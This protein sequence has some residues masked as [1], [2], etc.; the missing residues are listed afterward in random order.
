MRS[1]LKFRTALVVLT[2]ITLTGY[3]FSGH[4][5]SLHSPSVS[6]QTPRHQN[7]TIGDVSADKASSNS[8]S[9][10]SQ[11]WLAGAQ[12]EIAAREY[13][14]SDRDG[15]LQAPNR[16]QGFRAH[17]SQNGVELHERDGNEK[18][19][20]RMQFSGV[21]KPNGHVRSAQ[22]ITHNENRFELDH[23][24]GVVEWFVN[25][26][27]GLEHGY[28]VKKTSGDP[29]L[30]MQISVNGAL[31]D[32]TIDGLRFET[33]DG[34]RFD[35]NQLHAFDATGHELPASLKK[36]ARDSFAI[37][38]DTVNA[39]F[40]ITI[41]PILTT[42]SDLTLR[43]NQIYAMFGFSTANAGDVNGDGFDDLV[44]GAFGYDNGS[45]SEGVAFVFNGSES[46]LSTTPS[47]ILESNQ[48]GAYLGYSVS[49]A[50]D[51]N[52]DGFADIIVGVPQHSNGQD[53]E[54]GAY[55][56]LGSRDGIVTTPHV[57]VESDQARA[58]FG[59]SVAGAGDINGDGY[60][61]VIVGSPDFDNEDNVDAGA[62]FIYFGSPNGLDLNSS[63]QF[64]NNLLMTYY[65]GQ[66]AGA[67]D[68]NADGFD[69]VVVSSPTFTH[70]ENR[71][72]RV[73]VYFG[74]DNGID[75]SAAT[76]LESNQ[77]DAYFGMSVAGAGDVNGDGYADIIVGSTGSGFE[78]THEGAAFIFLGGEQ[79]LN[80]TAAWQVGSG[81]TNSQFGF[82]V[83][84]LGDV[85][86]DGFADVA[87][88]SFYF[89]NTEVDDGAVYIYAGNANGASTVALATLKGNKASSEFGR[90]VSGGDFNG[91][92]YADLVVGNP[93]DNQ[94][95]I[96]EGS[97][98][99]YG[100]GPNGLNTEQASIFDANQ[101]DAALGSSI[102]NAGDINGDGFNDIILG[103]PGF[104]TGF[105]NSGA[106]FIY[107]GSDT[108]LATN[109]ITQLNGTQSEAAFGRSVAGAGDVNGDG[110]A[111]I[112]VGSDGFDHG[113]QNEGAAFI[114]LGSASGINSTVFASLESNQ[115]DAQF[116]FSVASAGD[117]NGDGFSDIIVGS[118][119]YDHGQ[120]DEGAAFI[121][122]GHSSVFNTTAA[123]FLESNQ[124]NSQFAF[125]VA[126]AGDVNGDSLSDIAIG[127]P[128][129]DNGQNDEGAVFVYLG[130]T[131]VFA[132][133]IFATLDSNQAEARLGTSVAGAGDINGDGLDDFAS[134]APL[135]D[136]TQADA[137]RVFVYY[138]NTI[139]IASATATQLKVEQ[140]SAQFGASVAGA[141]DINSDGFAD[142]IVGSPLYDKQQSDEGVVFV[143]AGKA[144]GLIGAAIAQIEINQD[145]A[146]FGTS[147]AA[148]GDI[149][150]DGFAELVIG[151]PDYDRGES[152]EGAGFVYSSADGYTWKLNQFRGDNVDLPVYDGLMSHNAQQFRI[153]LLAHA[154]SG[155]AKVK[156]QVETCPVMTSFASAACS[157][158]VS[159]QWR[160][161]GTDGVVQ[162]TENVATP[163]PSAMYKWRA[164]ILS[165]PLRANS[166]RLVSAR[167]AWHRLNA[168][169]D[170]ADIRVDADSDGDAILDGVDNCPLL[171]NGNQ[172]NNDHDQ[173]GDACDSD[174]D[175][176][177][178]PDVT[179]AFP[180]DPDENV[181]S[182][183]DGI[184][185]N[186]D[187]DDDND[188]V[189]DGN[190]AFPLNPNESVDTDTDGIGNNAD[191]DDDGDGVNDA[192]DAFPLDST[193][194][195]DTDN[196]HIGNN[197]DND[198]D[199]DGVNDATDAFPLDAAESVDT[200]HDGIGNNSDNDDDGDGVNDTTD[201]FPLNAEES[202]DTDHDGIGNN[203]D[204]DDDGDGVNDASDAFPLNAAESIDT[205]HDGIGNNA[206]T[207]DDGDGVADTNDAFPL[208][209]TRQQPEP[210]NSDGGS[211]GGGSM[212][213]A[214]FA[215]FMLLLAVRRKSFFGR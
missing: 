124:A 71:E 118:P 135:Y 206:D 127:S 211:G 186:A 192:T 83:K 74:S 149:N 157:L 214:L 187:T 176:D 29:Q 102:A 1:L 96:Q 79:G 110:Y 112:I 183:Q 13:F 210:E 198:D 21:G 73:F 213:T 147:V 197:A 26:S 90:S 9:K 101:V 111:D 22:S 48:W 60:A 5:V 179:D 92:G 35:Y 52:G 24:D 10:V 129:F 19:L 143:F 119:A 205:D 128:S 140:V 4:L 67:G 80:T 148:A 178:A 134:G 91:D 59:E 75:F 85:N 88:G 165:A 189:D 160:D 131:N 139:A 25:R 175:N 125:S 158:S 104:D 45:E 188:G 31:V 39:H 191:N 181:D 170:S 100:G 99:I 168:G 54:G 16:A 164:R 33:A 116:G 171:A 65:G 114:Y 207:D 150:G 32:N 108:G 42:A 43:G 156:L 152:N 41:D 115:A 203:A 138:G 199:G 142:L 77:D 98:Q 122:L 109:A 155:R 61:D 17:F 7:Q 120:T 132:S 18:S 151:S 72:G 37:V 177:G 46:G 64:E 103:S 55:L 8:A 196:D 133:N 70:G 87:V 173:Q 95:F 166:S 89:D 159:E 58:G 190:D 11:S 154:T 53:K 68:I 212:N 163:T 20:L 36:I 81:Q 12:R 44:V 82:S 76:T 62:V 137:G 172:L 184:G 84:G 34:R 107:L 2:V 162:L 167:S 113:E 153:N 23:G 141:G 169:A 174:D 136:N 144:N 194:T 117:L 215:T 182:D 97:V 123:H 161:T 200:D 180:F 195:V 40:P 204:N 105:G 38:V 51:V 49:G 15:V 130:N 145:N 27:S 69:D 50:G 202:V 78:P 94:N 93:A 106:A 63:I 209:A 57:K 193:E 146:H 66:V 121:Y 208:D 30:A 86:G 201:A 56:Y 185:N 3:Y 14:I 126:K 6:S 28:I 47:T